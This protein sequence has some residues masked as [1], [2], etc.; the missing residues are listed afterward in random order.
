MGLL[1]CIYIY[2]VGSYITV[3]LLSHGGLVDIRLHVNH[4]LYLAEMAGLFGK[5]QVK[6]DNVHRLL[7][8]LLAVLFFRPLLTITINYGTIVP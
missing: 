1:I 5:T 6:I 3:F 8:L 2:V 4:C 7:L